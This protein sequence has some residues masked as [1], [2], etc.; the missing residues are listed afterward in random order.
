MWR[1]W[2]YQLLIHLALPLIALMTWRKCHQAAQQKPQLSQGWRQKWGFV[3]KNTR[4]NGL[5]IHA[6]S[7]GETRSVLPLIA[8]LQKQYPSLPITLSNGSVRGAKQVVEFLPEGVK[9]TFLPLDY[10]FALKRFLNRLQPKLILI[11]ETEIWPNLIHQAT[12]QNIPIYLINARL[13]HSSMQAYQKW[14]GTWLQA[15]LQELT[16]IA[17]QFPIDQHHF[18]QLGLDN[19]K[20]SLMGNL[21]FDLTLPSDLSQQAEHWQQ[22]HQ[23]SHRFIWVAAST[24]EGE[25]ALMLAA[26]QTLQ[27]TYPNALLILVPRQAD[28]FSVVSQQL[29][30]QKVTFVTRS[31][32]QILQPNDA[33]FLAD[34]VGEMLLWMQIANV[35]F[36]GGSLVQFGGHNILEP[37]ALGKPVIS[38]PWHHNLKAL[39]DSFIAQ[40]AIKIVENADQ[41]GQQLQLYAQN[42]N[43]AHQ[44]GEQA[45]HC[46]RSQTGA[47]SRLMQQLAP[48]LS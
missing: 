1:N 19:Q 45:Y 10:S 20:L 5:L 31:S 7:L 28:R 43:Q 12:Q 34:S 18:Q 41:L 36:I 23:T 38:G 3:A 35:S 2:L 48:H 46:F 26:H 15:R 27:Q 8:Q 30:Q 16:G 47:L 25:E 22:T 4:P 21:K 14:G 24:H 39:Y 42:P 13:K 44:A 40:K 29:T 11:V 9:H 32:G 6:V 33:V 37:A 17:C